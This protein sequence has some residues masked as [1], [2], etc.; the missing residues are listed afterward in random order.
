[1]IRFNMIARG[2]VGRRDLIA[3]EWW[4]AMPPLEF[5]REDCSFI[6]GATSAQHCLL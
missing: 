6:N 2:F 3:D 4:P 5:D 1:M